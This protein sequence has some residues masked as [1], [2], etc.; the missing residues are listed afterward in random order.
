MNIISK[1]VYNEAGQVVKESQP[2][3]TG[4]KGAGTTKTV[5]WTAGAN[6]EE[7]GCGYKAAWAGLPCIV[8]AAAEPTPE[9]GKPKL[10]WTKFSSYSTLDQ[11]LEVYEGNTTG[12]SRR[13]TTTY[14]AAGRVVST[15]QTGS[16]TEVPKVETTYNE[17]TGLPESQY[18]VCE[19]AKCEG[20]DTQEVKTTYDELGRPVKYLDADGNKSEVGYDLLGRPAAVWDGKGT[21]ITTYDEA[22]GLPTEMTDSAAGTFKA[23]YNADGQMTEQLLPNGLAQKVG[24]GPEG[25][26]TSLQYVKETGCSS[27]C[28]WL[29]FAREDS[30]AGQGLNEESTLGTNS[31]SYDKAGRLTRARETP[32]GEGCTTRSYGFDKDSNRT[33]KT[34]Y[35]PAPGGACST[36]T[37]A[38]KQTYAYDSADR[39]I[40]DGVEYDGLGRI[41]TLPARYAGPKESWYVGGETLAERKLE[42]APFIS[43]GNLTLNLTSVSARLECEMWSSGKLTG[44]E[45]IEESFE[46]ANCALYSFKGG[47]KGKEFECGTIKAFMSTYKGTAKG[48]YIFINGGECLYEETFIYLS[49]FHHKFSNEEEQKLSV[50]STGT[51]TFGT[52]KVEV[53]AAST[54]QLSGPQVGEKLGFKAAGPVPNEG[55]LTTGYYVNDLTHTQSQG[56]VTNTYGLDAAGR[57]RERVRT[58]GSEEGTEIYHYGGGSDSPAWT[59]DINGEETSWT[60]NISALGAGLGAIETSTGEVTLQL[61]DLHGDVVA[62]AEDEPE[63]T[64]LLDTQRYDEFGNPLESGA[65]EKGDPEYGWLGGK[66]RRTQ[67]PS[68]VIQ[69][70]ARSY[71]PAMGRFISTDPVPGGSANA[72]DY[73]DQDPV[74]GFDLEGECSNRR[75]RH[76]GQRRHRVERSALRRAR[77]IRIPGPTVHFEGALRDEKFE[78]PYSGTEHE[79]TGFIRWKSSAKVTAYGWIKVNGKARRAIRLGNAASGE[80]PLHKAFYSG[81]EYATL[82]VC[83]RF[84]YAQRG[85]TRCRSVPTFSV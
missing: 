68:G 28:T 14:D 53:S 19:L 80:S 63:A 39:L 2:S 44:T 56:G 66:A 50:E 15:H 65:L 46:L 26:A 83:A 5:Y 73:A 21:Q 52:G 3:D 35:G 51:A 71:V 40:G 20:F 58:G 59:E 85:V 67:L 57:Q 82:E 24:Y 4:G 54:W 38:A 34:T 10:P 77:N 27:G 6:P 18:F 42:S 16:G 84:F 78:N 32:S 61:S 17:D 43:G 48:M 49:S 12:D 79:V 1:T 76:S 22:S 45:G 37:E 81:S 36:E 64:K 29:S 25:T 30:I 70:G 75:C 31:Y 33:S 9:E 8:K 41:T 72:Y 62:A 13:T 69:M 23:V 11:P 60:R 74:N 55:E 7:S 47:K